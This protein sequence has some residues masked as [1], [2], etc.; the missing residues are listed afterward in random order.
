M[1]STDFTLFAVPLSLY[2][3]KARS[4]M[5]KQQIPFIEKSAT[6]PD[7]V[8]NI[9]PVIK[10]FIIPVVRDPNGTIIQDGTGIIDWFEANG[11]AK[12]SAYAEDDRINVI[13]LIFELFGGE[14]LLRPAMHYRWNKYEENRAALE[15]GFATIAAVG[16]PRDEQMEIIHKPMNRMRNAGRS[17]GV[18]E[19]TFDLI[20]K[21]YEEFLD[22]LNEH[23]VD[24]PYL[25]GGRPTIGDYGLITAMFAHLGRD[26][27]PLN[28]MVT[29]APYVYRWVERMNRPN[30]D[31][32]EFVDYGTD[33]ISFDEIPETLLALLQFIADDYLPEIRGF[34][35]FTNKY[36]SENEVSEGDVIGGDRPDRRGIGVMEFPYRGVTVP[37]GVLPYRQWLLQRI[38]DRFDSLGAPEQAQVQATLDKTGLSDIVT[39]RVSRR[40]ERENNLEVWGKT[41]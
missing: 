3:G 10:R 37:V 23:F 38:Q 41:A 34:V 22:L 9:L 18:L 21:H 7:F 11:Y 20:E 31:Q 36:L 26:P 24:H 12:Q 14:G 32:V 8:E 17:F 13:S 35:D 5:T 25:L 2:A 30:P 33:L 6:T 28:L 39:A 29:K 16:K 15:L 19:P 1:S 4:Y 27:H 40:I